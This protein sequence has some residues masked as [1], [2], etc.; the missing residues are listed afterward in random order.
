VKVSIEENLVKSIFVRCERWCGTPE[1]HQKTKS[2]DMK[3]LNVII[4]C[5]QLEKCNW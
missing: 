4:S 2:L 1:I 5:Y 3:K